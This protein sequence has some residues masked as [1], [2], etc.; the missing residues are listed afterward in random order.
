MLHVR[1]ALPVLLSVCLAG[2]G[3]LARHGPAH[4]QGTALHLAG[5]AGRS[6]LE[7]QF[8][9]AGA[10]NKGRFTKFSVSVECSPDAA[11]PAQLDVTV[12][13][14]SLDTGDKERDDTLRSPDMF[15]VAKFAQARFTSS[16]ITRTASG[17]D[18]VGK[19]L[20]HGVAREVHVPFTFRSATEQG[21]PVGYLAGK[22]SIKR[23][24][25]G[26]GQGDW[27]STEWVGN[28]VSVAYSVRLNPAH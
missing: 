8:E 2:G 20:L 15:D 4:A 16:R 28:E 3:L 1:P 9:Q 17:F 6:S 5:D 24:D 14:D 18:A 11:T 10:R 25:F 13:I 26:V 21:V 7:F 19:L 12:D 27:K 23:L 22:M